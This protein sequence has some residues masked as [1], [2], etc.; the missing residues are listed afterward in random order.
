M[1][2]TKFLCWK[3]HYT[4][5]NGQTLSEGRVSM[6]AVGVLLMCMLIPSFIGSFMKKQPCLFMM[7][8]GFSNSQFLI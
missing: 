6:L 8:V 5:K 4:W 3:I 1:N 2:I 7:G